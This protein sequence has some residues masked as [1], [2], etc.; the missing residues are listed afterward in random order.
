MIWLGTRDGLNRYDGYNFKV[1][2]HDPKDPTTLPDNSIL[3]LLEDDSGDLW[4]GTESGGLSRWNRSQEI[5]VR[6]QHDPEDPGSLSGNQVRSIHRDQTGTL[7]IGTFDSG[8]SRWDPRS[9]H[10]ESYRHDP[11]DPSSLSDDRIRALTHDR[12]GN[13]WIGTRGGLNLLDP[14]TGTFIR[15]LSDPGQPASL[16]DDRVLSLLEDRLGTLWVGTYSGLHRMDRATG[17]FT[18]FVNDPDDPTS[19]SENTIRVIFEDSSGRLWVGTDGGLNLLQRDS[20]KFIRYRHSAASP[21]SLSSDRVA[22]IFEDRGG[23]MWIGT[24]AGGLNKWNPASWAFAHHRRDPTML[25]GLSSDAVLALSEDQAGQLWI[26]T[27]GGLDRLDR[28]TGEFTNFRNDP[29]EATSLSDDRITA[30]LHD[31]SERLWIGT[32]TGGLNRLDPGTRKFQRYRHDPTRLDSLGADGVMSLLEDHQG[33]LW[34]GTFGAGL[35]QLLED[36][37]FA[38]FQHDPDNPA[39][40]SNDRVACLANDTGGALWVGTFG[41]G[42]NRFDRRAGS[43]LRLRND[44]DRPDSLSH[45]AVTALRVDPR[46]QLWI[47]TQGGGLQRLDRLDEG[48]VFTIYSEADGLP[49]QAISGI[50]P[51]EDQ[52]LWLSTNSGLSRFD[53]ATETFKNYEVSHGLQS[54]EFNLGA[55]HRSASGEMFFGGVNGFNAF[56]PNAIESRP[57]GPPVVLTAFLKFGQPV[58]LETALQDLDEIHLDHHDHVVSFEFAALDYTA[59]ARNRYAYRLEGLTEGWLDW[60]DLD[61]HRRVTFTDLDPGSYKLQVKG[62][63]HNGAWNEEGVSLAITVVPPLWRSWWAYGLYISALTLTVGFF[64]DAERKRRQRRTALFEAREAAKTAETASRVKSD[65]L[66][67]MSHEIRTPMSG[68]IGMTELLLLSELNDKQREQLETIRLSGE[69]LLDILN[70]ILDFSKIESRQLDI[71]A[72]PFDLRALIEEALSLVAPTAASK[73]LD[74]GYWIDAGTPETVIG[75]SARS[76]QVLMNLLSNSVKFTQD[77]GVFVYV[78]AKP[79]APDRHEILFSIEDS[80]IGIPADRQ[81]AIFRPFSQVD[82]STTRRYGGTGLGLAI[83]KRLTELMGGRIWVESTPDVGSTFHFTIVGEAHER[84]ERAHLHRSSPLLAGRR[85]LIVDD[86]ITMRR[87]LSRQADTWGMLPVAVGSAAQAIEALGAGAPIDMVIM[88]REIIHRDEIS[89]AKAWGRDG[90]YRDLPLVLLTPPLEK[91]V[92]NA[93][94]AGMLGCPD[95]SQPVKPAQ[96]F[97]TLT[98]LASKVQESPPEDPQPIAKASAPEVS[99]SLRILMAEDNEVNQLVATDLLKSLG[100]TPDVAGDGRGVLAALERERY[101]VVLM[102]IQMPEMDGFE[103]TRLIRER[104]PSHEQP[105]IVAMT[106]HAVHGYRERCLEAGMDDYVSKP[107]KLESLRAILERIEKARLAVQTG[108]NEK[109]EQQIGQEG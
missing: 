88:D 81:T 29:D 50:L 31:S 107:I 37:S 82:A 55:H 80:G 16:Q 46:G 47:G 87:L 109:I 75:D 91:N 67:N 77:G 57:N 12:L 26:G 27:H 25:A 76:R 51:E 40:L 22:S 11:A 9:G 10:F 24:W 84:P 89:W 61:N 41:G 65:F 5:F 32:Q 35:S 49:N 2:K 70:D 93:G 79:T 7:W 72:A 36:G 63:N 17:T 108:G 53:L 83:C 13:L 48:G 15:Y 64:F 95:L 71:E 58:Q 66:A 56:F 20:G 74:L 104:Y 21:N 94:I 42:L 103:A 73:H 34:V 100:F 105:L 90:R 86:N 102:D 85:V 18:H 3:S 62:A 96:L 44:P 14:S 60:I 38:R 43:F 54:N 4:V 1:Y 69:A 45:N 78:S 39:S 99:Q 59:P 52:A 8:V 98:D 33:N 101:D 30:L 97:A 28:L 23:V 106:A 6:Y 19:L 92:G 68:V